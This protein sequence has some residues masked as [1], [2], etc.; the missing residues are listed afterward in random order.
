MNKKNCFIMLLKPKNLKNKP[1]SMKKDE[2]FMIKTDFLKNLSKNE[3]FSILN[4]GKDAKK[5]AES[6]GPHEMVR[7][8]K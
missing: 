2:L 3:D 7:A 1:K 4:N 5:Y 8:F 6:H